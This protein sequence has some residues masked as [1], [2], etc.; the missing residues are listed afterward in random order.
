MAFAITGGSANDAPLMPTLIA[1]GPDIQPRAMIADKGYDSAGNR[2]AARAAGAAPVIPYRRHW[3][4]APKWFAKSL[5]KGRS[6]IE[7]TVGKL[8]R[9]RRFAL[10]CEKTA[11]NFRAM[12][13]FV[14]GILILKSVHTA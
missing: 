10:R 14:L 7:I 2:A 13:A 4:Q 6:R 9:F 8:K 1:K 3:K 5:Y 11:R 12:M